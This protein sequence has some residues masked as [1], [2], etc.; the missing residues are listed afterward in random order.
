M[1]HRLILTYLLNLFDLAMTNLWVSRYGLSIEGN[2]IGRWLYASNA[3][4]AVKI[5]AVGVAL[6]ALGA[7]IRKRPKL[8]WVA[9]IP[10]GVYGLLAVYHVITA[11][12]ISRI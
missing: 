5:F 8:A 7:C 10:L 6:A 11:I 12:I 4:Y 2:P 9:Y 1:K 3:V